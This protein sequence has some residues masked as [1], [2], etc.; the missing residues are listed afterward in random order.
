MP[1][2]AVSSQL[3]NQCHPATSVYN[4]EVDG[5]HVYYVGQD[6]LLVH[7]SC[8]STFGSIEFGN[9]MHRERFPAFLAANYPHT[10]FILRVG[11]GQTGIDA[12]VMKSPM[13]LPFKH[14]ELKP[15]SDSGFVKLQKQLGNWRKK[16]I[17]LFTYDE[18]GNIVFH[19]VW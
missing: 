15:L 4:L 11:P 10:K 17:A 1:P 13:K 9:Y 19:G 5:Q 3:T 14:A 16:G 7:N 8:R 12:T 6:G 2:T 18:L